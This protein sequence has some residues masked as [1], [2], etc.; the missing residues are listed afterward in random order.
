MR[1]GCGKGVSVGD[2]IVLEIID[3]GRNCTGYLGFYGFCRVYESSSGGT[4][5][6]V[7]KPRR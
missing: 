6:R 7:P 4:P 2:H 3:S 1:K 5:M